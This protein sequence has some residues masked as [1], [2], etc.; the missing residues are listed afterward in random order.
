VSRKKGERIPSS[1]TTKIIKTDDIR[2]ESEISIVGKI[3]AKHFWRWLVLLCRIPIV[4]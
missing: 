2:S 3:V 1:D 4:M